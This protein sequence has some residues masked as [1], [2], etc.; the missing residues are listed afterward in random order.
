MPYTI[1]SARWGNKERTSAVIVTQEAAAVAVSEVDTPGEWASFQRWRVGG[2]E[3]AAV[4]S[5]ASDQSERARIEKL[6]A[7]LAAL[8]SRR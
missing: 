8:E 2:G 6:E 4:P 7:A 5:I 3:V 1:I